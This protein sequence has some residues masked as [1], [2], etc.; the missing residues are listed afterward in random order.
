MRERACAVEPALPLRVEEA[1]RHQRCELE[2]G[3]RAV[4]NRSVRDMLLL[5]R[6]PVKK[7]QVVEIQMSS[8]TE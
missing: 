4:I 2:T 8:K 5:L 6:E 7:Q 1:C 3:I